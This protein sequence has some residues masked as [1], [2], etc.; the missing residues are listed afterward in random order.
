MTDITNIWDITFE[1]LLQ[2]K[3]AVILLD[4]FVDFSA[5]LSWCWRGATA[6]VPIQSAADPFQDFPPAFF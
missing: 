4:L 2:Y 1:Y 5:V 3:I 6:T